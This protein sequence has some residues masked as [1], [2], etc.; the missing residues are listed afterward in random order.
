MKQ[1]F[2]TPE[3]SVKEFSVE[4]ILTASGE[5]AETETTRCPLDNSLPCFGDE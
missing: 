4:D 3:I 1:P 5:A 2:E